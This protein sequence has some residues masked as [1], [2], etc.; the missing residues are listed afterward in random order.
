[1]QALM[2]PQVGR[3]EDAEAIERFLTLWKDPETKVVDQAKFAIAA[4]RAR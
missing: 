4:L 1:M 3:R 2:L